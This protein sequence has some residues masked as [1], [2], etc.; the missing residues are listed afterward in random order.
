MHFASQPT[1]DAAPEQIQPA[2]QGSRDSAMTVMLI[3]RKPL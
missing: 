2:Q 1:S 3:D